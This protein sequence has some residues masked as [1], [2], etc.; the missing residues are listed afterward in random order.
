MLAFL[1]ELHSNRIWATES[2]TMIAT[3]NPTDDSLKKK[4]IYEKITTMR[5]DAF[6]IA[7]VVLMCLI[8]LKINK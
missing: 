1:V 8:I 7:V 4:L 2:F 6:K 3:A 5:E